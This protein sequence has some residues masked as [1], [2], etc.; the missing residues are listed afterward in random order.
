MVY[1]TDWT[2]KMCLGRHLINS[3]KY[4]NIVVTFAMSDKT[5]LGVSGT[6]Y[7]SPVI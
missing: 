3:N 5:Q 4:L 2:Y 7:S 1:L 6:E